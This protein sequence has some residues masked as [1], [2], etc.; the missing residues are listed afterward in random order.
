MRKIVISNQKGGI[1]KTTTSI[2]VSACLAKLG[3]KVLLIDLDPQGHSTIGL[4]VNT[5]NKMTVAELLCRDELGFDDIVV[6]S[7]IENLD[8]LP[9]DLSLN[10]AES[11]LSRSHA[12]E[13]ILREKL[14]H[15]EYDYVII[16]TATAFNTI[17]S[18]AFLFAEHIIIPMNL[19]FYAVAGM[20]G[21]LDSINRINSKVGY[22]INHKLTV[23]GVVINLFKTQSNLSKDTLDTLESIF[24]KLLFETRIRENVKFMEAQKLGKSIF[25]HDPKSGEI[26]KSLTKEIM[27]RLI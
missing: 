1:G 4:G 21:L 23:L 13:F 3:K 20:Q 7:H 9:S 24:G 17:L 11:I 5:E 27:N 26:F 10:A 12:K 15:I 19:H 6:K 14:Q 16:D 22:L 2:N 18:N 25:D 8:I